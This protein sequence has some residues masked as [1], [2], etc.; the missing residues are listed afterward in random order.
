MNIRDATKRDA[1]NLAYLINLAGEGLPE[2][3]WRQMAEEGQDPLAFGALRAMREDGLF[4]Y[5]HARIVEIDG[6]IAGMLLSYPLPDPYDIG[7]LDSYPDVIRPLVELEAEVPGSWYVNAIATYEQFRGRGVA[8]A[9]MSEC[10]GLARAARATKLSL[11]V[12]SE[13]EGAHALYIKLG[14]QEVASRPLSAFP[15]GPDG[16]EWLLM[17]KNLD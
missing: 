4:S 13:N 6:Q 2:Y 3:Q 14:Y 15:G 17:V 10:D 8:S 11:I 12:A 1:N 7:E 5:H 9:L 16:G